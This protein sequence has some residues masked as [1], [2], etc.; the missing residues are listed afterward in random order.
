MGRLPTNSEAILEI[1]ENVGP[2][3]INNI[4]NFVGSGNYKNKQI[5][6]SMAAKRLVDRQECDKH[7]TNNFYADR[8]ITFYELKGK[9]FDKY[10][11]NQFSHDSAVRDIEVAFYKTIKDFYFRKHDPIKFVFEKTTVKPDSFLSLTSPKLKA[12]YYALEV[13]TK[14]RPKEIHREKIVK[15]LEIFKKKPIPLKNLGGKPAFDRPIDFKVLFFVT[16]YEYNRHTFARPG[17]SLKE[18]REYQN[19]IRSIYIDDR[20]KRLE[21][22]MCQELASMEVP[23]NILFA[24]LHQFTELDQ[25]VFYV[26]QG[27]TYGIRKLISK[28]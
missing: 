22:E 15:Y 23:N 10:Q 27:K 18:A 1:I 9:Q 14:R 6:L 3:T 2:I 21:I 19:D 17:V 7:K 26:N 20:R 11:S 8:F 16:P 4:F 5:N 28:L 13:E 24:P 12:Y 25:P